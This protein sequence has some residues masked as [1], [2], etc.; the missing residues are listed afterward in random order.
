MGD[1]SSFDPTETVWPGPAKEKQLVGCFIF[2]AGGGGV[3][4]IDYDKYGFQKFKIFHQGGELDGVQVIAIDGEMADIIDFVLTG[5]E[6]MLHESRKSPVSSL[7]YSKDLLVD[8][9]FDS[10][11][12]NDFY[13]KNIKP[14]F[15]KKE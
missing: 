15:Q 14:Y 6:Y 13:S 4:F 10:G 8:A 7:T 12:M 1:G 11:I 3:S 5:D 2:A 9:K